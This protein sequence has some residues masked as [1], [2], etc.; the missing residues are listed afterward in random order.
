MMRPSVLAQATW[1]S[2]ESGWG[3]GP[4]GQQAQ[5]GIKGYEQDG[6]HF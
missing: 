1:E 4:N 3:A 6:K 2:Q 5:G